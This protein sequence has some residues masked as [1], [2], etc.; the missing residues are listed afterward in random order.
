MLQFL[1]GPVLG[2]ITALL[3]FINTL[4]WMT[5]FFVVAFLKITI[6]IKSFRLFCSRI[7][8]GIAGLWVWSNSAMISTFISVKWEIVGDVSL[9]MNEWYLVIANHQSWTDI[10]VL[11]KA[12]N[13]KIPFLKFF[14]KKQLAYVPLLGFAWWALDF[15]FMKRH[16]KE[17]IAKRPELAGIDIKT[18]MKACEK[19]KHIPISVMNFVEGSRFTAEKKAKQK[20][21]YQHLL[22]PRAGGVAFTLQAMGEYLHQIIDVTIVYPTGAK[23]LW[24][25]L[26][27]KV[28]HVKIYLR[29]IPITADLIGDYQLDPEFKAKFQEW[30]NQLWHEKDMI[31]TREL[32]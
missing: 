13:H 15:P 25:L 6:P 23:T 12:L 30:L 16:T 22:L 11:G 32:G 7:L 29:Q 14:L 3:W 8:N 20:S 10:V 19:F 2:V 18:T 28:R 4:F 26:S 21:P 24:E 17:Q 1:R 31:L 27:G 5:P 9:K